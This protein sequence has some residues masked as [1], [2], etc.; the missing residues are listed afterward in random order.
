MSKVFKVMCVLGTRPEII[1]MAPVIKEALNNP[2]IKIMVV[3]T[4]QHYS[5][6]LDEKIFKDLELPP[7]HINIQVGSGSHAQM[8]AKMMV[9]LEKV[10]KDEKPDVVLVQG[11]TNTVMAAALTACKMGIKVGHIEAG[12]RSNDRT[13]PEEINRIVTDSISDYLFPPTKESTANLRAENIPAHKVHTVGNTIVDAVHHSLEIAFKKSTILKDKLL[14]HKNY[15]LFTVHRPS[16]TDTKEA[17]H[18]IV[19]TLEHLAQK[20]VVFWPMHPRAEAKL[21]EHGLLERVKN[22]ANLYIG[23]PVGFLDNL[24][25]QASAKVVVTDSGGMQEES[26]ILGTPTVTIRDNTERPE[27]LHVGANRL[28]GNDKMR[29]LEA[30]EEAKSEAENGKTWANPFGDGTA[31]QQILQ[32]ITV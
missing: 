5:H 4:G 29:V 11:D 22:I 3:H 24:L 9:K 31:A 28:A 17:L 19:E 1:K 32:C 16:N 27:T 18:T 2:K 26:C 8:T 6:E 25:L 10:F 15:L 30:I 7:A 20:D 12:L 21:E 13:M 14:E 23:P